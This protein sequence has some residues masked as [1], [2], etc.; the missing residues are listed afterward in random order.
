MNIDAI[1][2]KLDG[3]QGNKT[4][5]K[6]KTDYTKIFW[7][8]KEAGEYKIRFVP[9]AKNAD[10]PFEEVLVHYGV[11]KF[12]MYA[13]SNWGEEDP[14]HNF[15]K[16]I[17]NNG[18]E[19]EKKL[20]KTLFPKTR[21]MAPIVV[22]GEEEK[23]VRWME[24]GIGMYKDLLAIATDEDY[25]DYED[26]TNGRDFK[27]NAV[28][29]TLPNGRSFISLSLIPRPKSTPLSEDA[30]LAEKWLNDQPDYLS[31]QRK[32]SSDEMKEILKKYI[33]PENEITEE[34]G[35]GMNGPSEPKEK[36]TKS[37]KFDSMFEDEDAPF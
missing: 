1:K 25:M 24:M 7:K 31:V 8:P 23:G 6:E 4:S 10:S 15:A 12:P 5:K 36:E 35:A 3:L 28:P 13:L 9:N 16:E 17:W 11:N 2:K 32:Y 14:I 22:R 27:V 18:D 30:K 26:I 33:T 19:E 20:A 29:D 34:E 21:V 37:N